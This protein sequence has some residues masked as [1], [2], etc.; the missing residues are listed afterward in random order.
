MIVPATRQALRAVARDLLTFNGYV[1]ALLPA[2][3]SKDGLKETLPELEKR[4]FSDRP[5]LHFRGE[6]HRFGLIRIECKEKGHRRRRNR[7]KAGAS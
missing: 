1:I 3:G 7:Q 2:V 4:E 5:G 6:A